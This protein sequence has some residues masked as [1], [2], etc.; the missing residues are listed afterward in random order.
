MISVIVSSYSEGDFLKF[1]TSLENTISVDYELIK[2]ENPGKFSLSEAYNIGGRKAQFDILLFVHEDVTF[3]SE[4]WGITLIS[5]F[6]ANPSL[7]IVGVAGSHKKSFLPTGW[8]TGTSE[9]DRINLIQAS[10][11]KEELHSTRR[12]NEATENVK[13]IDGVFLATTKKTWEEVKFDESV[14]GFHIYDI[15][16]SLQVTQKYLGVISYEIILKHF[17]NGNYNSDWVKKT[18]EYHARNDKEILFDPDASYISKSRRA[19]YKALTFGD[20]E[21]NLRV[22]YLNKMGFDPLSLLH[23]FA[24][25]FPVVGRPFFHLLSLVGL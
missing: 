12:A 1:S 11:S 3:V 25:R 10:P 23:A 22:E 24:F 16:F 18:L 15:D 19:W 4:G 17:S 9:F 13:V 2:I 8:G 21:K 7:G 6:D 14:F 5:L 20:I